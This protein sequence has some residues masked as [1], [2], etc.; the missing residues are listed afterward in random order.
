M[1]HRAHERSRGEKREAAPDRRR[2]K[3]RRDNTGCGAL[4]TIL[5]FSFQLSTFGGFSR[6][7][8]GGPN[9]TLGALA[10][11]TRTGGNER[12]ATYS[13][14]ALTLLPNTLRLA[15]APGCPLTGEMRGSFAEA[16]PR[17]SLTLLA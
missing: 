7:L 16:S 15:S 1:V 17:Q 5:G 4:V 11:L 3:Q 9:E 13:M 14:G 8:W 12:E 6:C 10:P 2:R